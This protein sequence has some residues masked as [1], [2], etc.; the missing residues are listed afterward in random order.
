MD[1]AFPA[2]QG[3]KVTVKLRNGK[4]IEKEVTHAKGRPKNEMTFEEVC[5]KFKTLTKDSLDTQRTDRIIELIK[6]LERVSEIS[7]L[8]KLLVN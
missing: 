7:E 3:V 4:A 2:V 8:T 1:R 6:E 5:D